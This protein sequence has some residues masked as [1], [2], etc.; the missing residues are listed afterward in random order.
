VLQ[1]EGVDYWRCLSPEPADPRSAGSCYAAES[2]A[3]PIRPGETY[4]LR[5]RTAAGEL[6]GTTRV[7]DALELRQP[8]ARECALPP[9]TTLEL[10]WRPA[11]GAWVYEVEARFTDI[12]PALVKLGVVADTPNV[13]LRLQG[14]AV[15]AGDTTLLLPSELGL[16]DRFDATLHPIL[17]ALGGGLPDGVSADV[18]VAAADRNYVNWVRGDSFNPSGPVRVP[19]VRGAGTGVFGSFSS[20]RFR[21]RVTGASTLPSCL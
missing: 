13:P 19:S 18:V 3:T 1:F 14:L 20:A 8:Q 7:P 17:V 6:T 12:F 10:R 11:A 15:T 16:F 4:Q 9:D 21:I 2:V 5:V